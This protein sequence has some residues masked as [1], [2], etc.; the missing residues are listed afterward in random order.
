MNRT[1]S[2]ALLAVLS[3]LVVGAAPD[4]AAAAAGAAVPRSF[5]EAGLAPLDTLPRWTAPA[6]D[7]AAL[8]AEDAAAR[9]SGL[10]DRPPRVGLPM[11]AALRPGLA[12]TWEALPGA[13]RVWR[14]RVASPGAL[15]LVLGFGAFR[16]AE[17]AE[18][19]VY[20]PD[21]SHVLGPFTRADERDHGRL[22][23]PPVA[24]DELV[25]ELDW[26]AAARDV[27]PQVAL[28]T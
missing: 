14:V 26:P 16:P 13:D 24:G 21:R 2:L 23:L 4:R 8:R 9:A 27:V 12:G 5:R 17:G 6:V 25:I 19:W 1:R 11:K 18:L 3:S 10:K 7:V 28:G 22:W 15:W 20:R